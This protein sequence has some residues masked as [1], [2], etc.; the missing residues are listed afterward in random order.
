MVEKCLNL[1]STKNIPIQRYTC[2]VESC[3]VSIQKEL[4]PPLYNLKQDRQLSAVPIGDLHSIP[5][6]VTY[7]PINNIANWYFRNVSS[8]YKVV[9]NLGVNAKNARN[10]D[11]CLAKYSQKVADAMDV[12][13]SCYTGVKHALWAS[14]VIDDYA[15]MPKGSAYEAK[16]YFDKYPDK[17]EKLNITAKDLKNLPA[18]V[19]IV[20]EKKGLDGHIAITNGYGQETSDSTDNMGWLKEHGK[21]A[22]FTAYKLTD[23]WKYNRETMKL[24]FNPPNKKG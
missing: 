13:N 19:I 18:G 24:E 8:S 16:K 14:G 21:G 1:H 11:I 7:N 12:S 15:D 20:Y 9:N 17:F 22:S 10:I 2:S 3:A 23:N 4:P 5:D 6:S